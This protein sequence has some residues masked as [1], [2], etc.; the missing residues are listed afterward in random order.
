MK[1]PCPQARLYD[2]RILPLLTA[3]AMGTAPFRAWPVLET[4]LL[5]LSIL[6]LFPLSFKSCLRTLMIF[7]FQAKLQQEILCSSFPTDAQLFS[8]HG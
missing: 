1:T 2:S 5:I 8:L 3:G 6:P 4:P 7:N